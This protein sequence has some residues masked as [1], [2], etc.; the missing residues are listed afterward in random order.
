MRTIY[1]TTQGEAV[2]PANRRMRAVWHRAENVT[3]ALPPAANSPRSPF[4]PMP[5][6]S[7]RIAA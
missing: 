5:P 6:A 3:L 7:A 2:T 1:V 4:Q